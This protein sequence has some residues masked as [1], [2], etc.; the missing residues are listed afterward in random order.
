MTELGT[1]AISL[2][3]LH[4]HPRNEEIYGDLQIDAAFVDSI[5]QTGILQPPVVAPYIDWTTGELCGGYKIIA[6]HR[7]VAAL[8]EIDCEEQLINCIVREYSSEDE[9]TF[10]FLASNKHR[11]KNFSVMLAETLRFLTLPQEVCQVATSTGSEAENAVGFAEPEDADTFT[12]MSYDEIAVTLG[13][14]DKFVKM[15]QAIYSDDYREKYIAEVEAKAKLTKAGKKDFIKTWDH[16]RKLVRDQKVPLNKAYEELLE[17][18]S[19]VVG[20]KKTKPKTEK[21]KIPKLKPQADAEVVNHI[22][23]AA[24]FLME[25][26]PEWEENSESIDLNRKKFY[27][28]MVGYADYVISLTK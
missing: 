2:S 8:Q 20:K 4:P 25:A 13:S 14:S 19:D 27:E 18:K 21:L 28:I 9:E 1:Q 22:D 5:R 23:Q 26:T 3:S 11:T 15:V 17:A 7:R 12:G 6:G 16:V 10:D 24:T